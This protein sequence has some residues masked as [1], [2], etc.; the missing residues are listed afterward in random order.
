MEEEVIDVEEEEVADVGCR[1]SVTDQILGLVGVGADDEEIAAGEEKEGLLR[2]LSLADVFVL[3]L[4]ALLGT[5]L[6]GCEFKTRLRLA[7][8]PFTRLFSPSNDLSD[9]EGED[10]LSLSLRS[11]LRGD[12]S[13][14]R[15]FRSSTDKSSS[16]SKSLSLKL[17]HESSSSSTL[18]MRSVSS[19]SVAKETNDKVK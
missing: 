2:S 6:K 19:L 11:P 16:L 8:S 17:E 1:N 14:T 7:C 12:L 5:V 9:G 18:I 15:C 13:L 4:P 3:T 10:A